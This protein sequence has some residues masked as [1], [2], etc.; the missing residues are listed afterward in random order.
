M[1]TRLST[2]L[3]S[4]LKTGAALATLALVSSAT[5]CSSLTLR[6]FFVDSAYPKTVP[7]LPPRDLPLSVDASVASTLT[8][9]YAKP[10]DASACLSSIA[11]DEAAIDA[12]VSYGACL[13][14]GTPRMQCSAALPWISQAAPRRGGR[15]GFQRGGRGLGA[16]RGRGAQEPRGPGSPSGPS[17]AGAP[18]AGAPGAPVAETA[19][20][21]PPLSSSEP[22]HNPISAAVAS[23]TCPAELPSEVDQMRMYLS[24]GDAAEALY[25]YHLDTKGQFA[26]GE[27]LDDLLRAAFK[28]ALTH[29]SQ[30]LALDPR[31][32]RDP[33]LPTLAQ[34]GG[35]ANGA[36]MAGYAHGLFWLREKAR[37]YATPEQKTAIDGYRFGGA[38]T[39]SV[40]TLVGLAL[41]LY[42]SDQKPT[43]P[44]EKALDACIAKGGAPV[45]GEADRKLQDCGLAQ[46]RVNFK[47]NEWDLLCAQHG[48]VL[49]LLGDDF[50]GLLRFDPL[51]KNILE[52]FF[53][54]FKEILLGNSFTRTPM[55][56]DMDQSVVVGLDERACLASGMDQQRCLVTATLASIIEPIFAA[57][58][59]TVYS[60]L[61]GP[62]GEKGTWVDGSVRSLNPASRG[63]HFGAGRLLVLNPTRS[64]GVPSARIKKMTEQ[65]QQ[66]TDSL[67]AAQRAW[68]L[69]Y[70]K[71]Y[72]V[73]R[74]AQACALGAYT[75]NHSLCPLPGA[76]RRDRA[77]AGS[78]GGAARFTA[79]SLPGPAAVAVWVPED[80]E[81]K[82]LFASGYTFDPLVMSALFAWG[83]QQAL[84]DRK[85]IFG[86]L[87]W[88][89]LLA[90]E[91]GAEQCDVK[92]VSTLYRQR[93]EEQKVIIRTE[94]DSYRKYAD[95]ALW[96][97]HL[98]ERR[99]ALKKNFKDCQ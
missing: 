45:S 92:G 1:R 22:P 27:P 86:W 83:Q 7:E 2:P 79:T 77:G 46:L 73:E 43:V 87:G 38:A 6:G 4:I 41:D 74:Q 72:L 88:C 19:P 51:Q 70:S 25:T 52:P 95:R 60:G 33:E 53:K 47:Q 26:I 75:G 16:G 89:A 78:G 90:M 30:I 65:F 12:L 11:G 10:H 64:G 23:T 76:P 98:D 85:R 82:T 5:G 15:W 44:Q 20:K 42:F 84:K 28:R 40:G 8:V 94:V 91:D 55:V 14:E 34:S 29:A 61:N 3:N 69:S 31:A 21:E 80:I 93:V 48:T 9:S 66:T 68:E 18:S 97:K 59:D 50:S 39:S 62:Q 58:M 49:K 99:S 36:F 32:D 71:S 81:P 96:Q 54:D 17:A 13:A 67:G 35:A 24:L 57:P 63:A 56:V 37:L